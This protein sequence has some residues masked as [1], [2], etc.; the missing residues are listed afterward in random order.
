MSANRELLARAASCYLRARLEGEAK[1]L[2]TELGDERALAQLFE[3]RGQWD[4]AARAYARAQQWAAA[5]EAHQRAGEYELAVQAWLALGRPLAAAWLLAEHLQRP[6]QARE[7][8]ADLALSE[9]SERAAAAL[10]RARCDLAAAPRQLR[11]A[12][13][14]LAPLPLSQTVLELH[15]RGRA[16]ALRLA[17]PDLLMLWHAAAWHTGLPAALQRWQDDARRYLGSNTGLPSPQTHPG[18]PHGQA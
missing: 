8:L 2:W 4:Q 7:L 17:R 5:A 15:A 1:R 3:N 10:V 11:A 9:S 13:A 12:L 6:L 16:L 14:D 18:G